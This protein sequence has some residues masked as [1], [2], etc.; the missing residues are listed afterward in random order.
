MNRLG[1]YICQASF[2]KSFQSVLDR[3]GLPLD[4]FGGGWFELKEPEVCCARCC[5][6]TARGE[7]LYQTLTPRELSYDVPVLVL[8]KED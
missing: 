4:L 3:Q 8:S 5:C 1:A 6:E 7:E 2:L